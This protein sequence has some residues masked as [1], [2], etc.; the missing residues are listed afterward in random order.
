MA[1]A[2][3]E[4]KS[5]LATLPFEDKYLDQLRAAFAPAEFIHTT[6]ANAAAIDEALSTVDVAVIESDLDLRYVAAPNLRWVH[7][8]HS[9][10]TRSALPEVFEKGLIVTGTAGRSAAALAQHAFFFALA[11]T[12]DSHGLYEQQQKGVWR[13]L[14]GYDQR[15][16]L[17]GKTLGVIGLGNT[18]MEL[19]KLGQAFGMRVLAYRR[20][21]TPKPAA[22]SELYCASRGDTVDDLLRDS[23]V[24]VLATHLS[25][26]TYHLIGE[27]ELKLMK[28]S[29]YLVNMARGSVVDEP[30]LVAA[31][32]GGVIAGAGLDVF[33]QEPLPANA[34]IRTA[35]H[36]I[37]TSHQTPGLPDKTQRTI[38]MIVTNVERYR[39]GEPML[40]L[41]KPSD[42]YT[43]GRS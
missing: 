13:G 2:P 38:D 8:G 17:W 24:V 9:G 42:I 16:S 36:T 29:A 34:L 21:V 33:E 4:I 41:M 1:E 28:P 25:D 3:R 12:F 5:V 27:R 35:P 18:G 15:L 22:V 23:D 31:L 43:K 6:S 19:V 30:A 11:L 14:Q 7:C 40:N 26:E 32:E 10:L 39:A 37:I 20:T